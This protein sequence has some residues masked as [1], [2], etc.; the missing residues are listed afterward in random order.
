MY[1]AGQEDGLERK[2]KTE[3][4]RCCS[5]GI[6]RSFFHDTTTPGRRA[7]PCLFP[8][9][10]VWDPCSSPFSPSTP[11][12]PLVPPQSIMKLWSFCSP[13]VRSRSRGC[14]FRRVISRRQCHNSPLWRSLLSDLPR[15]GYPN[16]LRSPLTPF[17]VILIIS[18]SIHPPWS[19]R[20]CPP[21]LTH[22]L[23]N[24]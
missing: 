10:R 3:R 14:Y 5:H 6:K 22:P 21:T 12:P 7:H 9:D 2:K 24:S 4:S 11:P 17:T 8:S 20:T 1:P 18:Q 23:Y 13:S 16:T 15:S 19:V